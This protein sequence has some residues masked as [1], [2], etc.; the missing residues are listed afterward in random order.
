MTIS[1]ERLKN[2]PL[3]SMYTLWKTYMSI[4]ERVLDSA[5]RGTPDLT[6]CMG[7]K[8]DIWAQVGQAGISY[9][10]MITI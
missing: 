9:L 7:V 1:Y 4:N 6:V 2:K 5:V 8:L 10:M 3:Q